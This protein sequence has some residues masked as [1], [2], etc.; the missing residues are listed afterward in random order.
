MDILPTATIANVDKFVDSQMRS[1]SL[2][3]IKRNMVKDGEDS[4]YTR[5]FTVD[6]YGKWREVKG[7]KMIS[8]QNLPLLR[9]SSMLGVYRS[10]L[11]SEQMEDKPSS[12]GNS[13]CA[14]RSSS[15]RSNVGGSR[16]ICIKDRPPTSACEN[17]DGGSRPTSLEDRPPTNTSF[18]SYKHLST[19]LRS[20]VLPGVG[21][22]KW[23][24]SMKTEFT[25]KSV[26]PS[27]LEPE[28]KFGY[29]KDAYMKWA[30]H[31]VYRQR[32]MKAWD[33]YITNAPK[34]ER[35]GTIKN[36]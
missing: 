1:V 11:H 14:S 25:S 36:R 3:E 26:P 2:D 27:W 7:E 15:S 29:T 4:K 28:A 33:K 34:P 5:K 23:D 8:K 21:K 17:V 24:S 32:L 6:G 20:N 35:Q 16:P 31:D 19:S 12:H 30:E 18:Q 10:L 22:D 9:D 13:N